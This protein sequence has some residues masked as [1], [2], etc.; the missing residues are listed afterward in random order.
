MIKIK[1]T[2]AILAVLSLGMLTACGEG[3]KAVELSSQGG[4]GDGGGPIIERPLED[5]PA[6]DT[7]TSI[8]QEI[9]EQ[10]DSQRVASP[11][12]SAVVDLAASIKSIGA[13]LTHS[14][15]P[16]GVARGTTVTVTALLSCEN[17]IEIDRT[18]DLDGMI[19]GGT[20]SLGGA[21]SYQFYLTC[22]DSECDEMV[23][24]V[25]RALSGPH[26]DSG[27]AIVHYGLRG[28]LTSQIG[29]GYTME[30]I[31]R[32]SQAAHFYSTQTVAFMERTC[33]EADAERLAGEGLSGN[34]SNS[35]LGPWV[36]PGQNENAG[37]LDESLFTEDQNEDGSDFPFYGPQ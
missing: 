15:S 19:S 20:V 22:S 24:T 14:Q 3:F 9:A 27:S 26:S 35:N 31:S 11:N 28:Q 29:N 16:G 32:P 2:M 6:G 30:Y 5:L 18:V 17:K 8:D 4:G 33:R 10:F 1:I 34:S 12:P 37:G 36:P 21:S 23:V 7:E 13:V 25:E